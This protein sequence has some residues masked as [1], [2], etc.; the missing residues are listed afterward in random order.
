MMKYQVTGLHFRSEEGKKV[1]YNVGDLIEPTKF[2][3]ESFP[4]KFI[5]IPDVVEEPPAEKTPKKVK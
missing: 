3:L 2:E 4:D 1:R 5:A